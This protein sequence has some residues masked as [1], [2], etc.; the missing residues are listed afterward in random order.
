MADLTNLE[1]FII[2]ALLRYDSTIETGEGSRA[3]TYIIDP[4]VSRL[5]PD[6]VRTPIAAFIKAR[7]EENHPGLNGKVFQDILAGP[8]GTL[9]RPFQR[10]LS[11]VRAAT[12]IRSALDATDEELEARAASLF[13][14][15]KEGVHAGVTCRTYFHQP[16]S[17]TIGTASAFRTGSGLTFFPARPYFWTM[18]EVELN[19]DSD[20]N[21][22]YV[23]AFCLAAEPGAAYNI[24]PEEIVSVTGVEGAYEVTN[25]YSADGVGEDRDT[26]ESLVARIQSSMSSSSPD[27]ARGIVKYLS[28]TYGDSIG[29]I[30]VVGFGDAEMLRDILRAEFD[31]QDPWIPGDVVFSSPGEPSGFWDS[32]LYDGADYDRTN[33]FYC[34]RTVTN[35]SSGDFI[36]ILNPGPD[37]PSWESGSFRVDRILSDGHTLEVSNIED[38]TSGVHGQIADLD[39]PGGADILGFTDRFDSTDPVFGSVASGDILVY[40]LGSGPEAAVIIDILS[41]TSIQVEESF[42]IRYRSSASD[43]A[44]IADVDISGEVQIDLSSDLGADTPTIQDTYFVIDGKTGVFPVVSFPTTSSVVVNT[45]DPIVS[46]PIFAGDIGLQGAYTI[47]NAPNGFRFEPPDAD[48]PFFVYRQVEEGYIPLPLTGASCLVREAVNPVVD[49]RL[50]LSG[51]VGGYPDAVVDNNEVHVG[52]CYDAYIQDRSLETAAASIDE[53]LDSYPV[54]RALQVTGNSG[55]TYVTA[56]TSS[57]AQRNDALVITIGAERKSYRVTGSDGNEIYLY[58][59]LED[60]FTD[61]PAQLSRDI[62]LDPF[63]PVLIKNEGDSARISDQSAIVQILDPAEDPIFFQVEPGDIFEILTGS[64]KGEYTIDEVYSDKLVVGT[65]MQH[66]LSDVPYRIKASLGTGAERP[67]ATLDS[68][69]LL[70][71]TN[72]PYRRPVAIITEAFS[73]SRLRAEGTNMW[74]NDTGSPASLL[75][76]YATPTGIFSN[77]GILSGEYLNVY[78]GPNAGRYR[79]LYVIPG[80]ISGS[81]PEDR[82]D[83]LIVYTPMQEEDSNMQFGVGKPS[84]GYAYFYFKD[85][86]DVLIDSDFQAESETGAVFEAAG[87]LE[88]ELSSGFGVLTSVVSNGPTLTRTGYDFFGARV[89]E[90]D[91]VYV[92]YKDLKTGYF[93]SGEVDAVGQTLR[94]RIGGARD[95]NILF[96]GTNPL[97]ITNPSASSLG[98][99]Q[100]IA[101]ALRDEPSVTVFSVDDGSG[102]VAVVIRGKTSIEIVSGSFLNNIAT[103]WGV[104]RNNSYSSS[105]WRVVDVERDNFRLVGNGASELT[106]PTDR[107]VYYRIMRSQSYHASPYELEEV[108][109]LYRARVW[110]ESTGFGE[111]YDLADESVLSTEYRFNGYELQTDDPG[112]SGGPLDSTKVL[113]SPTF[114]DENGLWA[115]TP[116]NGLEIS[117]RW[118]PL[119]AVADTILSSEESRVVTAN[120]MVKHFFLG[121]VHMT[122]PVTGSA[123][124]ESVLSAVERYIR[125]LDPAETLEAFDVQAVLRQAG[126]YDLVEPT[127]VGILYLDENRQFV[128]LRSA[129]SVTLP[130]TVK[131]LPEKVTVE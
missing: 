102:N 39:V 32:N 22:Y 111:N 13:V 26:G 35:V 114:I 98:V 49:A 101:T 93:T 11:V 79:I 40:D 113:V 116:T 65:S 18:D 110:L 14:D 80:N 20:K 70:P 50:T 96:T 109:G 28:E 34:T 69:K 106:I 91:T 118:S 121:I 15:V 12:Q 125:S 108:D 2:D 37:S 27:T 10:E 99:V 126:V 112:L 31:Y 78:T 25:L 47:F 63:A 33:R 44:T 74:V 45:L 84:S 9:L 81:T 62:E 88:A 127:D 61:A 4:L 72:V 103:G 60:S 124:N 46:D 56:S 89:Q 24:G 77:A 48:I 68:I 90:F 38:I 83:R 53:V 55:E 30:V 66:F 3:R 97:D 107:S 128:L 73:P 129:N 123:S 71:S 115:V 64:A 76:V 86:L 100:Q 119:A 43:A 1:T 130:R 7:M 85:R 94:L 57:F 131:L 52:G 67:I 120:T 23:D 75:T 36:D 6:P 41:V 42:D 19:F 5:G 58:S 16:R 29:A 8:L 82:A 54:E 51:V 21:L 59:A 87:D 104:G 92:P 95:Y 105:P 117:Y 122:L 17:V